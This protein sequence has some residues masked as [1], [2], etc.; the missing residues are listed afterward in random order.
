MSSS[1][2]WIFAIDVTVTEMPDGVVVLRRGE[3]DLP[4]RQL[5]P[6]LRSA[7]IGMAGHEQSE[8]ELSTVVIAEDGDAKLPVLYYYIS[9]FSQRGLLQRTVSNGGVRYATAMATSRWCQFKSVV[10]DDET[11]YTL[12]RFAYL[13]RVGNELV[14]ESPLSHARVVLHTWHGAA[15]LGELGRPVAPATLYQRLPALQ[16]EDIEGFL[17][18]FLS[19]G[20]LSTATE[21]GTT[22][23][24][25]N[26][27]LR[28]WEFHDLLFHARSRMGRHQYPVGG[29]FRF[30]ESIPPLPA[31]KVAMSSDYVDL[32]KPDLESLRQTDLPFTAVLEDRRSIRSP[33]D[34]PLTL[35]QLSEFLYR[36]GR[37]KSQVKSDSGEYAFR[38]Y[39]GGGGEYELEIYLAI[40]SCDDIL[41][42]LYH[43]A[44]GE[45]RLYRLRELNEQSYAMLGMAAGAAVRQDLPDALIVL[46]A[47]FQRV[48][49]KY[50]SISYALILKDAGVL[51]Q[52]MYLVATAMGLAPCGIGTG[53]SDLFA[54]V[55]GLDY[56]VE[57]SV[58]EFILGSRPRDLS[59]ELSGQELADRAV[60][61]WG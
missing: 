26:V 46:S 17:T 4:L 59:G 54:S 9:R 11:T 57:T 14:L 34:D 35:Q 43:Y 13:H 7:L 45:H 21:G 50:E 41:P 33:G 30:R 47:R 1:L 61:H 22:A 16:A 51:L 19:L 20:L 56:L 42:G 5:S 10:A 3:Q 31:L 53:D 29:T 49:W 6:G 44:P 24:D 60:V 12:S 2:K 23:E 28:Q 36:V 38:V 58:G 37:V 8:D 32:E 55:A 27:A 52:T 48:S 40:N 15:L 39:P 25:D 18:L